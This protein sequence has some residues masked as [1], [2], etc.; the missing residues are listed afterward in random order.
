MH[1]VLKSLDPPEKKQML[2]ITDACINKNKYIYIYWSTGRLLRF[3]SWKTVARCL[4]FAS[5]NHC[6]TW[7][8]MYR[9]ATEVYPSEVRAFHPFFLELVAAFLCR[10]D[11]VPSP[12]EKP[13]QW[14]K[15]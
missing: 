12:C 1:S 3:T 2:R 13:T 4:P 11:D 10:D 5:S 14:D 15:H 7:G 9:A 8:P 6:T